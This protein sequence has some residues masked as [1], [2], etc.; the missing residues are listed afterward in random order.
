MSPIIAFSPDNQLQF[1]LINLNSSSN[2]FVK[3]ESS[4]YFHPKLIL[5]S[6]K[7]IIYDLSIKVME[8]CHAIKVDK[9]NK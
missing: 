5:T 2:W 4:E 6:L 8:T 7:I 3:P 1:D 9:H